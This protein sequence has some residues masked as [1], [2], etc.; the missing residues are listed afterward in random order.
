MTGEQLKKIRLAL[1]LSIRNFAHLIGYTGNH[2]WQIENGIRPVNQHETPRMLALLQPILA[3][4]AR[5]CQSYS[6]EI[7]NAR[8]N[9]RAIK[10]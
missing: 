6:L 5:I 8:N 7:I 4:R 9:K 3:E 2:L 10:L 1:G